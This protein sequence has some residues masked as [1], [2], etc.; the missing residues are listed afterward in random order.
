MKS[1]MIFCV[2]DTKAEQENEIRWSRKRK[3]G[4]KCKGSMK[5]LSEKGFLIHNNIYEIN[6]DILTFLM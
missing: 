3:R 1:N 5:S 6:G 4:K 2:G